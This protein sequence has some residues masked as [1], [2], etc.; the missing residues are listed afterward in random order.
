[1]KKLI[2]GLVILLSCQFAL[3]IITDNIYYVNAQ[4]YFELGNYA[5]AKQN[6]DMIQAPDNQDPEYALLRGKVHLALGDYKQ[7]H[8]WLTEY[9]N[10]S[11]GT[12]PLVQKDLLQML[13]EVALYQEQTSVSVSLGKLKGSIN[14][15]DSE[16]A[17][18]F[19]PDN[20]Y[21]YFSSLRR[22]DFGKENIFL[23]L[24]QNNVWSE[25]IEVTEL[26]TDY[27]ESF[28][29]LSLDGNTAYLFGYYSKD[30][31]NGDIYQTTLDSKGRWTKPIMIKEVSSKYYDLQPFVWRD[32]V[33]FLTSNRDGDHK[34]YDIYVSENI[35]GIWTTPVSVG[36]IVNTPYDEQ[37]PFLSP[38][39]KYLYFASF[40]HNSYGGND[41]FVSTRIGNSWTEW[42]K[43]VNM[44]PIINSV[45][46]D[47]YF[48]IAPDGRTA[49]LCS[50]RA[51]GMGQEDI[52]T[53]D[54]GLL[55][56]MKEQ[57]VLL[58]G[59][60]PTEEK[61]VVPQ[62][63]KELKISGVVV[64]DKNQPVKTD[65]IWV[66]DLGDK[67]FMRIIGSDE[68]GTFSFTLPGDTKDI[69]FE[70]NTPGY[71]KTT[72]KI[73]IPPD[74]NE[75]F[76][77]IT[78][79]VETG[80]GEGGNLA[81]NGKVLDEENN[82]VPCSIRWSYVFEGE[83]TEVIVESNN[84]G[85]FKL[86]TPIMEKLKYRIEEPGYS[87]REEIITI[88]KNVNSYDTIIRL[89]RLGKEVTLNGKVFDDND[90]PLVAMVAWIYESEDEIIEYRVVTDSNGDYSISLPRV[91]KLQYRVS[92]PN[93]L[94]VSG[95]INVP[96][97]RQNITKNFRLSKLEKEAVF[98]LE[99]VEFEFNK[100]VLTPK[101][102][103]ILKPVLATMKEN[104]TLEIE[105]SGHTDNIG[106]KQYNQKLSEARAKAVADYLIKNGIDP[107]R[108]KTVG[109]GF[110]K[111]IASNDTPEGRQRNRRT[112]MK[113]LGIEYMEDTYENMEKE[114]TQ[115]E[116][117]TRVVKTV[118]KESAYAVTQTGIPASLE[119]QFKTMIQQTLA[120]KKQFNVKVDLFLDNGKIQSA[121][122][123]D[124]MG[125]LD[126]NTTEEIADM[127]LGW[128]V[129]SQGRNIYSFTVKK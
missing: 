59:V 66:Y 41:I 42:S 112:E 2:I 37:S 62:A 64:S 123:R 81:I 5:S 73:E 22:S 10:K 77:N 72:G 32:K 60:K 118:S 52:Y 85:V 27:N 67:T 91:P 8:I 65:I 58:T 97:D 110:D 15:S 19:T 70:I 128:K 98:E 12:D 103:E 117:K 127:M 9:Q 49:Y 61:P 31:T 26:C 76:V 13:Y 109:Y 50:N 29:S 129:Q 57:I 75:I 99:N 115:A 30:T 88:P 102:M 116:K 104:E 84:E 122:V 93:Y 121:N 39:G 111:P 53:I 56:K 11:L 124:L 33:M 68:L 78:L 44:G 46:D 35:N 40:G 107:K 86:Y 119:N 18:V 100:A 125:N 94:Q 113:I 17:P 126:E 120:N 24:Q 45:K 51:G 96:E 114:F 82:P 106:S 21:M 101:S 23:S 16:Y 90:N 6:L 80:I 25:A 63:F 83:L 43:P 54:L 14:T 20:K 89:V 4:Q 28:G 79:P 1:M 55:D 87:V 34:N 105:L 7:A 48:V 38:D 92:K 71:K 108:I 36:N 74:K 69:A 47:R 3:A 95:E